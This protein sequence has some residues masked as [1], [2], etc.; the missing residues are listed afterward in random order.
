MKGLTD[1]D[2]DRNKQLVLDTLELTEFADTPAGKLS[3]G[4]KRKLVCA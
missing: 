1:E 4:N 2:R 3:G